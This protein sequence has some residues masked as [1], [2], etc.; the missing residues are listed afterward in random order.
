MTTNAEIAER[1][2]KVL[3]PNYAPQPISIVRGEGCWLF[4]AEGRRYLDLMG[5]IATA[6]LGHA[7]PKLRAALEAQ[8]ALLW[9]VSNLFTT[10]PQIRLAERLTACCF[11]EAIFFCNS[12]AEANEAALKLAR[13]W[14]RDQGQDRFEIIAFENAFH[15]RTLF[16]VSA[17][18]TPAYWKG[19]EPMVPGI[20][21]AKY[22]DLASV[23]ALLSP[24]T[25]AIIVEPIQG[26]G[27]IRTP[28]PGFLAGLRRLAD[29]NGCLLLFDEVQTGMG[30]TGT[31]FAHQQEGVIPDVMTLAKALGGGIPIGAMCTTRKFASALVPGTHA[32]TFGG[33]PL[34]CAV[35]AAV[36]D[37][38]IEGGV[39]DHAKAM[40]ERLGDGLDSIAASL[41]PDKVLASRGRGLLRGLA[42][43]KPVAGIVDACRAKG[44]L[45]ISAGGNVLRMA[46]PL[47]IS[48]EE[49]DHGLAILREVLAEVG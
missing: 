8:A 49:I 32:S 44:L 25:A 7:H 1:G 24:R 37:E 33:N 15:G 31:M 28:D 35:A 17:T 12:G 20:H 11:A 34:A 39:L 29:Q 38:L 36:V 22:N 26:E 45:V 5:G 48:P 41:G 47:V 21:H 23:E 14:H 3:V 13:K 16:T 27:G 18:G 42:L 43:V 30:R 10:E 2:K 4:D 19:F 40:G 46:P 6:S 9:H